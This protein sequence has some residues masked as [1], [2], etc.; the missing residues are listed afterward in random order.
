MKI[1]TTLLLLTCIMVMVPKVTSAQQDTTVQRKLLRI[2]LKD[3]SEL[4]GNVSDEDSTSMSFTTLS[5]IPMAI[6]RGQVKTMQV[7][8]GGIVAGEY[9]HV[10]PNQTRLFFAPTGRTLKGGEG[11]FSAYEIFFP[12]LAI[13]VTDFLNLAGGISL[14]PG[15]SSQIFYLA[16]RV[17]FAQLGNLHL[18][19]GVLYINLTGEGEEG[20]GIAYGVGTFGTSNE[21]LTVGLGWGF[22]QGELQNKPILLIGGELRASNTVKFISENWIPPNSD[23]VWLSIGV[24]FF[25]EN[26]AAD[27]ALVHP[28]GS[29]MTGFPFIPWLGF[30]YNFGARE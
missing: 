4:I 26:L 3:G 6:P 7:L 14:V 24:R 21:A 27:I 30:A 20:V 12:F 18:S 16:P 15:A 11:Y 29:K 23:I 2:V 10:D 28:A 1:G 17:R 8:S 13:G 25:G 5:G 22:A 19:G 9:R